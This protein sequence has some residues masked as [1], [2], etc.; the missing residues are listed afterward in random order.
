MTNIESRAKI[1]KYKLIFW[2]VLIFEAIS[3]FAI[4]HIK[5]AYFPQIRDIYIALIA[6]PSITLAATFMTIIFV[7]PGCKQKL[8][9]RNGFALFDDKCDK[10]RTE[11]K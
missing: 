4:F 11:F 9:T 7:C 1:A 3:L 8:L 10:C 2:L 6:L 5:I